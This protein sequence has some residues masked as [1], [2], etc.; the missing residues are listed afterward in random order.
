MT[1]AIDCR[2][3]DELH[4]QTLDGPL[5]GPARAEF[6][7]HLAGCPDCVRRLRGYVATQGAL[8]EIG[9]LEAAESAPPL[10]ES[11]VAAILARRGE[12]TRRRAA[13]GSA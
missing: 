12:A 7:E 1:R 6:D 5:A 13:R 4:R 9:A 2:R 8:A 10:P 3:F 11:L